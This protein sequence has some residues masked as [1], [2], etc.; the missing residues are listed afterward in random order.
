[1]VNNILIRRIVIGYMEISTHGPFLLKGPWIFFCIY[2]TVT[3]RKW[4]FLGIYFTVMLR[5]WTYPWT[6]AKKIHYCYRYNEI[7]MDPFGNNFF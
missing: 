2:F 1:M 6:I 5:T 7:S 4:V 3:L